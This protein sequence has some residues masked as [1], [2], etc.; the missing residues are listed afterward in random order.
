MCKQN[1]MD[2]LCVGTLGILRENVVQMMINE[3]GYIGNDC[4]GWF[5]GMEIG[6]HAIEHEVQAKWFA[7]GIVCGGCV[8]PESIPKYR[9]AFV[10]CLLFAVQHGQYKRSDTYKGSGCAL[11]C[12]DGTI[13]LCHD[14]CHKLT[15]K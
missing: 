15:E 6:K 10:S 13:I 9:T 12:F 4:V 7:M 8:L 1:R 5:V 14:V 11:I 2:L 3:G